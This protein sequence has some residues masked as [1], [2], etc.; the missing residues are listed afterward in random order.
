MRA[1]PEYVD[2]PPLDL[3]DEQDV[4]AGEVDGLDGDCDTT[5]Q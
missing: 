1:Y 4:Q 2:P 5:S 3:D